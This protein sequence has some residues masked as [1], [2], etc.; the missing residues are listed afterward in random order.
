M[1]GKTAESVEKRYSALRSRLCGLYLEASHTIISTMPT[2]ADLNNIINKE[3]ASADVFNQV[4]NSL[5]NR[6]PAAINRISY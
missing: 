6:T 3:A 4:S 1:K 2:S 5:D